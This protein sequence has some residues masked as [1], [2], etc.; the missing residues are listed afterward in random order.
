M[1]FD[2]VDIDAVVGHCSHRKMTDANNNQPINNQC[3]MFS[4]THESMIDHITLS[5]ISNATAV[6]SV[7]EIVPRKILGFTSS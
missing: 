5:V 1:M 2:I 6:V 4:I 7:F 3:P